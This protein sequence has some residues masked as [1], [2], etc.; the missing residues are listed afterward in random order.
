[1]SATYPNAPLASAP[2]YPN[3][4]YL[5]AEPLSRRGAR[6]PAVI[7]VASDG[8][9]Q[10]D[11]ALRVALARAEAT[12]A[13]VEVLTI[14]RWEPIGGPEGLVLWQQAIAERR[15]AQ[16]RAVE[17][18]LERVTGRPRVHGVMV[19]DGHPAYT[20]SRVAIERHAALVIVGL[21]RH[22]FA[23]R[24]FSDETALQLARISRVPVLAVPQDAVGCE[25]HAIVAID[26]ADLSEQ[27]AQAAIDAVGEAG[28]VELVHVAPYMNDSPFS[29][30]DEG[31]HERWAHEQLDAVRSR[32]AIPPGVTVSCVLRRGRPARE[33]LAYARQSGAD[34]I[35]TGTH[36]RGFVARTVLGSVA[37]Q[38]IRGAPCA[39]LSV[40][41]DPLPALDPAQNG[42]SGRTS[43]PTGE[44]T[45]LLATFS[46][47][48]AGRR[49]ILEVDD[50]DLGAQGQEYN[51]PLLGTTY[52]ERAACV[53]LMLGDAAAAGRRL[54]R[55]IGGVSAINVLSD[56]EGRDVALR[57]QH[58]ASQTLLTFAA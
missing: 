15:G 13:S 12:G 51:Y 17:Q 1:M 24:L 2:A 7:I 38:L 35:A 47:R 49:T 32:L 23:D 5:V 55:R 39:V 26:F 9:E 22:E 3:S 58:G 54:T 33:L 28:I 16:R 52:D 8:T 14:A 18:Q 45:E 56:G 21:G 57:V 50:L 11:G 25:T 27:A 53:E 4:P 36:G 37:T 29:V 10:S 42:D 40:P 6:R 43:L 20:I 46:R 41:R 31:P 19:L 34:F 30:E 44:W 48:N